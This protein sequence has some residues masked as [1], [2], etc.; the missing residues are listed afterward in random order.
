MSG[1][2]Y[3]VGYRTEPIVDATS[4]LVHLGLDVCTLDPAGAVTS[5]FHSYEV[6]F[7]VL[8]GRILGK[9]GER[10]YD[11]GP[12][13]YAVLPSGT[14]IA[15]HNVGAE[16]ARWWQLSAPQPKPAGGDTFF[17]RHGSVPDTG[18]PLDGSFG[19]HFDASQVP[20][21]PAA[22]DNTRKGVFSKPILSGVHQEASYLDYAPGAFIAPHDHPFEIS[23][24]VL[25]GTL[26][27]T[28]GGRERLVKAGEA[29]VAAVGVVHSAANT[30][31]EPARFIE[32][33]VP[34]KPA[35]EAARYVE[36]WQQR[37]RDLD[38]E[39]CPP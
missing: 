21:D 26:R 29:L 34:R 20:T 1:A 25:S 17:L 10:A 33:Y 3:C 35:A 36:S 7:Y 23:N 27:A 39:E 8:A 15:W 32:T 24:Y 18:G 12:G 4:G 30:G 38:A 31:D 11:L 37:A 22:H 5:H 2:P 9:F 6:G 19:G 13:D 16:G 14:V 28:V